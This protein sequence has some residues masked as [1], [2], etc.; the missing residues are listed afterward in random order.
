MLLA[1]LTST[2]TQLVGDHGLAAVFVLMAID[3]VLPA[4]SEIVLL[5]GGAIASGAFA[6][7]HVA[8][9]GT[10]VHSGPR[11]LIVM[12]LAGTLGY[13][14]GSLVG[15][16]IGRAGGRPFVERH[17]RLVH[18][19]PA[20]LARAERWFERFGDWAVL[21]GRITPLARS[22]VS[23]PAGVF[24]AP[25]WRYMGL[26]LVGS[27]TWAFAL[28]GAGYALGDR[29]ETIHQ[30][31]RYVDIAVVLIAV[32]LAGWWLLRRRQASTLASRDDDSAH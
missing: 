24:D 22:F 10:R 26:T 15:W 13:L 31:F 9:F 4:A 7:Q 20:Q 1:S 25:F 28:V 11:A 5:Y 16:W 21:L 18:L 27:A 29:W 23:I 14:L 8:L 6:G 30:D 12:G 17:G 19:S 32:A 3:A 2:F